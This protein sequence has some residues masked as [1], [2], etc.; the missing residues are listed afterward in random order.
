MTNMV[1]GVV[2]RVFVLI[3]MVRLPIINLSM[4]VALVHVMQRR[5]PTAAVTL[6]G[7]DSGSQAVKYLHVFEG[8]S[9]S[10]PRVP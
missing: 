4:W 5:T 2:Y 3:V 8:L 10:S 7:A 9:V 6:V 1:H